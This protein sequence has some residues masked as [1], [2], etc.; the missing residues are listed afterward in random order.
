MEL[1]LKKI[2]LNLTI[3]GVTH[4]VVDGVCAAIIFSIFY[5]QIINIS[6]F[7]ALV[8]L[9]NVLAFGLQP[10]VGLITDYFKSPKEIAIAGCFFTG[11]SAIIFFNFPFLAIIFAGI[12]NALFHVGGGSISLNLTPRKATAPGIYVAP[13]AAGLLMGSL[14]GK[15]GQFIVWPA[16]SV[17]VFL[18]LLI[19]IIEKPKIDYKKEVIER[20]KLQ[21]FII[22]LLLVF[23][24]ISIRS[25]VGSLLIF[26]WEKGDNLI[27]ILIGAVVLGKGLGGVLADKFGWTK[28]AIGTLM[29]SIPFLIL[30]INNS[31]LVIIGVFLFN[32][33]MP[34][35]LV[36]ISNILL[37]RP[38][39][40]FGLPC[41]ALLIGALPI[42]TFTELK[43][44]LS[45]QWLM[46]FLIIS[47]VIALY[48]GLKF[49]FKNY[50]QEEAL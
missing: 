3:Y 15:S 17:L 16:V 19:F 46:L 1:S 24:S 4:A 11:F 13:G 47:S 38:G 45:S 18:C 6:V 12:G 42:L 39:F 33:T 9:Y 36:V 22:I 49:Y 20:D 28:I 26:P 31:F 35:T 44:T 27:F 2:S 37:G 25:L 14:I 10:V 8:I 32:I 30:G 5:Y 34:I 23:F 7:I 29:L 48:Y 40:A 43:G 50:T 41:L 21:Y